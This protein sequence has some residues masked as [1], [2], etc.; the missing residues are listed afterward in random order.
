MIHSIDFPGQGRIHAEST[1]SGPAIVFVHADF[2]DGRMWDGVRAQLATRYKTVAYDKLGYGRSDPV[3]GPVVRRQELAAVVDALGLETIHLVGCSN[4][5]QQALDFT[6][7]QPSRVRSLTLVNSSPSGWQPEGEMP[8]L[9]MEM[10]AAVQAGDVAT[11]SELQ[12]RI[13]FDG[14]DRDQAQFSPALLEARRVASVMNRVYVE[15]GTF[16]LMDTQPPERPALSRL[17]E[18]K[19][20]TLVI[21]GRWDWGDNRRANRY[22]AEGIPGARRIEVEGG[23]VAPLEDPAGIAALLEKL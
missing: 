15:R 11:A 7:E 18:V 20:P 19:A 4:G 5:G 9:L 2:V 8:P 21:D 3:T 10:I 1:G 13:W 16:F 14:P 12:L 23:H 6:L 17:A 22:L